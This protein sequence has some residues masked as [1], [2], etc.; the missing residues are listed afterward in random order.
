MNELLIDS[1]NEVSVKN[2]DVRI[3]I[4][5]GSLQIDSYEFGISCEDCG[6]LIGREKC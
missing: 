3:C 5:C 4:S 6:A 2:K 1:G